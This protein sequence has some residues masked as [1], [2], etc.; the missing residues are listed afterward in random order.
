MK[1]RLLILFVIFRLSLSQ[2]VGQEPPVSLAQV[3]ATAKEKNP[4]ILAA[5]QSWN[6]IQAEISPAKAWPNPKFTYVDEKFP[7]GMPGTPNEQIKH[8]RFEQMVPF[9]G[10][11]SKEGRMKYH[12]SLVAKAAY[13]SKLTDV[14]NEVRMRYYELYRT[15]QKISL[16]KQSVESFRSVLKTAQSRL[17]SGQS[18]TSDIFM[19]QMELRKMENMLFQEQQERTLTQI[20]LNT[21]LNQPTDT[22]WGPAQAPD[23]IDPPVSLSEFQKLAKENNPEYQATMHETNHARAMISRN[24]L[25][26]AP[27]FDLMYER[28]T[29]TDGDAGR[30][31]GI[32]V[33]FPLW[34]S[35]PWGLTKSANAHFLE[36]DAM[37]QG[38]R[39]MVMKMVHMELTETNTHLTLARNYQKDILPTAQSNLK[40]VRQQYASGRGDFLRVLEAFRAWIETNNEYQEQLYHYSEH[41]SLLQKWVGIDLSNIKEMSHA[42]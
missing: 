16:A 36:T 28:E 31:I 7:S 9:P 37:A 41:W 14:L 17:A 3:L 12:E 1:I 8:Y 6:V 22:A 39:N 34:L 26:Y 13:Q 25:E 35:R 21:L 5:R 11:L 27:D 4:D 18:T 40:I 19:A 20:E 10:K 15:D 29:A 42:H 2:A 32:G 33:T 24:R 23:L 30:Q 38:M